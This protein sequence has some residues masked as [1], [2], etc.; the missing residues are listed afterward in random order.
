MITSRT[1]GARPQREAEDGRAHDKAPV[2]TSIRARQVVTTLPP[3]ERLS[4]WA[5]ESL[6]FI[7]RQK[8]SDILN[9]RDE[10]ELFAKLH[11]PFRWTIPHHR[12]LVHDIMLT[13]QDAASD[14]DQ[15]D[16]DEWQQIRFEG[17]PEGYRAILDEI[18][19]N[20]RTLLAEL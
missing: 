5:H 3:V 14:L 8:L 12:E 18:H 20:F 6:W 4:G 13:W 7:E 11:G 9:T 16:S 19:G 17:E 2:N 1:Q 10:N 15:L